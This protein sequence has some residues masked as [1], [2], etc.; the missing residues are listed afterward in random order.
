MTEDEQ[1]F[2]DDDPENF[3]D[4]SIPDVTIQSWGLRKLTQKI[5]YEGGLAEFLFNYGDAESF[6]NCGSEVHEAAQKAHFSFNDFSEKWEK[7][8]EAFEQEPAQ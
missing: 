2:C 8:L 6:K 4:C 3:D 5:E 7:L 1:R